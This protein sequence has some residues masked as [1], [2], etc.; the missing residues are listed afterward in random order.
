MG[1]NTKQVKADLIATGR[2][3]KKVWDVLVAVGETVAWLIL[4]AIATAILYRTYQGEMVLSDMQL[5]A[6]WFAVLSVAYRMAWEFKNYLKALG[7]LEA[8]VKK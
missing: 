8:G 6:V 5:Y 7:E 4:L 1:I 2:G 3:I